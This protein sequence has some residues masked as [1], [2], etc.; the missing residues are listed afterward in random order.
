LAYRVASESK[1]LI[2]DWA[3]NHDPIYD[4]KTEDG[5]GQ[6]M[7]VVDD[8]GTIAQL[9]SA[10]AKVE[11][12]YIADG[13]HRAAAASRVAAARNNPDKNAECNR[14]LA[15]IFPHDELE[16]L[17]YNRIVKDLNGMDAEGFLASVSKEFKVEASKEPVKP[18]ETMCFGAYLAGQWYSLTYV[19][20]SP[21]DVVER[22]AVSILQKKLLDPVLGVQD[23]QTDKRI[24]FVGGV[25]G[26]NE[27]QKRVDSG[28]MAVAFTVS[29]TKLTELMDVSDAGRIM[30][31]K[32]T[33]FE[34]KLR[35]GLLIHLFD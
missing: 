20:P 31:P 30:P 4:F 14:F 26:T 22:L 25:R 23:P 2:S 27:L 33:W 15:M 17:D 32:S 10:F 13:H 3:Q 34:P 28:E 35:S 9:L 8:E 24:D 29:P 5:V 12:L 7:W 21:E 16:I 18:T 6:T 19:G 1:K 11:T